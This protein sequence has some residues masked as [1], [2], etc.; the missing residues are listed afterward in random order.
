MIVPHQCVQTIRRVR[1]HESAGNSLDL[2]IVV[3]I[4]LS[5]E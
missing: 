2:L 1:V 4:K 5:Y 3:P